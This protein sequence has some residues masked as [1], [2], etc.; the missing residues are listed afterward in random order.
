LEGCRDARSLPLGVSVFKFLA[1]LFGKNGPSIDDL[2]SNGACIIDVRSPHEFNTAHGKE[3]IN[4]PL[5]SIQSKI[6]SLRKQKKPII[7]CCVSGMRS[8]RAAKILRKAG[9]E[10]HNGGSWKSIESILKSNTE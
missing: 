9:L 6:P 3:S 2:L 8:G 7:T 5:D 10:A 4:I 1:K